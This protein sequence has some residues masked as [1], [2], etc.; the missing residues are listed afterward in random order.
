MGVLGG[1][2]LLGE[3]LGSGGLGLRVQVLNLGLTEDAVLCIS[4]C[5]WPVY[6]CG[7]CLHV[8]V[9]VGGLVDVGLADDE[10]DLELG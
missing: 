8:G 6:I 5:C 7:G 4:S 1:T 10:E 2:L 9:G 3:L